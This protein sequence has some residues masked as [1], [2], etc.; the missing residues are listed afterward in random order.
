M[1][2]SAKSRYGILGLTEILNSKNQLVSVS[3]ISKKHNISVKFLE[4]CF[5]D[6]KRSGIIISRPGRNGGCRSAKKAED[7]CVF[8][9]LSCLE[10]DADI[11]DKDYDESPI[12]DFIFENVWQKIN[13]DTKT[14]LK[15]LHF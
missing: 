1:K 9:V 15:Q 2:L 5:S 10:G 7:I 12:K 11:A 13:N 14:K 6:L 3:E 8:D 4:A